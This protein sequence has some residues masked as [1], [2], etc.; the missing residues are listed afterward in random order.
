MAK[1][2]AR[3][4]ALLNFKTV[5]FRNVTE[6]QGCLQIYD[7]YNVHACNELNL[8]GRIVERMTSDYILSKRRR[9]FLRQT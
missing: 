2:T 7:L 1:T 8:P 3:W 5:Q 9:L 6:G 4:S